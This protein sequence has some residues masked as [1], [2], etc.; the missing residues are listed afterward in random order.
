MELYMQRVMEEEPNFQVELNPIYNVKYFNLIKKIVKASPCLIS[1][2]SLRQ[3]YDTLL[4]T[5][6]LKGIDNSPIPLHVEVALPWIDW[7]QA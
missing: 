5:N 2:M 6:L 3:I 1:E 4:D 7:T